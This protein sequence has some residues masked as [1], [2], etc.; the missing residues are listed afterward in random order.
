MGFKWGKKKKTQ[1]VSY[2]IILRPKKKDLIK[3]FFEKNTIKKY[4]VSFMKV[5]HLNTI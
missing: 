1:L 5:I 2:L 3:M 4:V